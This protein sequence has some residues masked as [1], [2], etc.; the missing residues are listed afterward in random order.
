M[1][2]YFNTLPLRVQL[3]ELAKCR[4]MEAEEFAG[5]GPLRAPGQAAGDVRRLERFPERVEVD[6]GP[7]P[8]RAGKP[9]EPGLAF[10]ALDAKDPEEGRALGRRDRLRAR[11][12]HELPGPP[13]P[14][15][16]G[17]SVRLPRACVVL[18]HGD[19]S[20]AACFR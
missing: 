1:A 5:L 18:H 20:R 19:P 6:P 13:G 12:D 11:G 2:N 16:L 10:E 14:L 3:E 8:D 4:F 17:P 15:P 7:A 9:R